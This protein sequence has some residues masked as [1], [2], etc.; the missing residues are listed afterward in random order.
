MRRDGFHQYAD[1]EN[2]HHPFHVVGQ[3]V[4]PISV[5]TCSSVFI[6]KCGD[7]IHDFIVP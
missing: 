3:D 6:W 1:A 5:P 4:Q 2:A 7:P